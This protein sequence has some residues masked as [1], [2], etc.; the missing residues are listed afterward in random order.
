MSPNYDYLCEYCSNTDVIF[1]KYEDREY[2][3]PC[4]YCGNLTMRRAYLTP[5]QVR[6]EKLSRTFVDGQ[7]REGFDDFKKIAKLQQEAADTGDRNR[8]AEISKE[9]YERKKVKK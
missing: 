7:K 3:Q 9:I 1:V 2:S 8:K 5:V 6:T 4:P